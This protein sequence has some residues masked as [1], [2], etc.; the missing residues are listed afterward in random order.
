MSKRKVWASTGSGRIELRLTR[1]DAA[2]ASH[3]GQCDDDVLELSRVPYVAKQLAA[4][5]SALLAEELREYGA[6]DAEQ[7]TDH[8]QNLQRILWLLAGD[9]VEERN[10]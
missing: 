5:D 6:W 10:A 4:I 1:E 2:S 9:I 8:D 7:L 3:S